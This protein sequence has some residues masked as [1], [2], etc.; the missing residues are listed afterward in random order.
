MALNV[1]EGKIFEEIKGFVHIW[2]QKRWKHRFIVLYPGKLEVFLSEEKA[3][4]QKTVHLRGCSIHGAGSA[5]SESSLLEK[6]SSGLQLWNKFWKSSSFDDKI[7]EGTILTI[8]PVKGKKIVVLVPKEEAINWTAAI[9]KAA[10]LEGAAQHD[11]KALKLPDGSSSKRKTPSDRSSLGI[12]AKN[13]L[14]LKR[15]WNL[16]WEAATAKDNFATNLTSS[17]KVEAFEDKGYLAALPSTQLEALWYDLET[18]QGCTDFL[19]SSCLN[20]QALAHA[21]L[22]ID[23]FKGC[24]QMGDSSLPDELRLEAWRGT[25]RRLIKTLVDHLLESNP[26]LES[27]KIHEER[28]EQL[29]LACEVWVIGGVHDKIMG[30]CKQMFS[31]K[32]KE[33]DQMLA[34]LDKALCLR[35]TV[36]LIL[37]G[38]RRVTRS[39]SGALPEKDGLLP[40]TDDLLSFMLLLMARARVKYL[41]ANACYMQKFLLV[42]E[43]C[44]KGE[45]GYHIT[46]FAAACEYLLSAEM[47]KIVADVV[48]APTS[49][50]CR[51]ESLEANACE[52]SI[53]AKAG[54]TMFTFGTSHSF[55]AR[56]GSHCENGDSWQKLHHFSTSS[57]PTHCNRLT[58]VPDERSTENPCQTNSPCSELLHGNVHLRRVKGQ[59]SLSLGMDDVG[60]PKWI[61]DNYRVNKEDKKMSSHRRPVLALPGSSP[62]FIMSP[63]YG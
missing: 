40:C 15:P 60:S 25:L 43:D 46:N 29:W 45:L 33:L 37:A 47:Q 36:N 17:E 53:H 8:E 56:D 19:K 57:G 55:K 27:C 59:E 14:Q 41:Q 28:M 3:K 16:M 35:E 50:S 42:Q 20:A 63:A 12:L 7:H 32:E 22:M 5:E 18:S 2:N 30:A 48:V 51:T 10:S 31:M 11:A 62:E 4:V 58:N 1:R 6:S 9:E 13:N 39:C 34:K 49:T 54:P 52:G 61:R 38:I 21:S 24:Y 44:Q 23:Y 26:A